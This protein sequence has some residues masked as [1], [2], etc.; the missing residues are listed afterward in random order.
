M[1]A[2]KKSVSAGYRLDPKVIITML[3][4]AIISIGIFGFRYMSHKPCKPVEISIDATN[5]Y[6]GTPIRFSCTA[7]KS[8]D[9][10]W[11]VG[12]QSGKKLNGQIVV[13]TYTEPGQYMIELAVNDRCKE[14]KYLTIE[15]APK[16][17]DPDLV[18]RIICSETEVELGQ[19]VV[20]KDSTPKATSWEWRFG[21]TG[22][23]DDIK[24]V[25]PYKFT[26]PGM[27][28]V[29]LVINGNPDLNATYKIYVKEKAGATGP[30]GPAL[31]N[32]GNIV[33][34]EPEAEPINMANRP[35]AITDQQFSD[36]LGEVVKGKQFAS[37]FAV[38]LCE[39]LKMPVKYKVEHE[40]EKTIS[41][42]EM[43]SNLKGMK[44]VKKVT[45]WLT[46]DASNGCITGISVRVDR[47]TF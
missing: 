31:P 19:E 30:M 43:C 12:D 18:P 28:T 6:T 15:K 21:E 46:I 38:Y 26:T 47:R 24:Q 9:C 11:S 10:K 14:Y 2:V 7:G 37:N 23:V 34:P 42:E 45:S 16:I 4:I 13:Y 22:A 44:R 1:Q 29:T 27:K 20:F 40:K 32:I 8:D 3:V 33:K 39:Y 41:F 36:M 25:A 5:F 35:P 17:L